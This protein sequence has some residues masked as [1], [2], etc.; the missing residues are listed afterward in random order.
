[1]KNIIKFGLLSVAVC[2][3][4]LGCAKRNDQQAPKLVM[5]TEATFPPYEFRDGEKIVGIDVEIVSAIAKELG[6]ELVVEDTK[7]DSVIPAVQAGKADLAASGITVTEDRKQTINFT[8][9]YV[10]AAQ[11]IVVPGDSSIK[12]PADLKGKRIGV[13]SGTTGDSYVTEKIQEPERFENAPLAVAAMKGGKVDVV[14]CDKDPARV[15]VSMDST[16]KI[17][18]EPLTKEEYAIAISKKNPELLAKANVVIQKL[19]DSG[20]LDRIIKKYDVKPAV[21]VVPVVEAKPAATAA[22]PVVEA[23]PVV[24]T[25]PAVEAKPTAEAK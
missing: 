7:F 24:E 23:K 4:L 15:F 22:V 25:K 17:L 1:M 19:K 9:P 21:D 12:T 2:A 3:S 13:Q 14:V 10:E 6:R 11:V 5:V 18:G 16:I 8:I 20:E